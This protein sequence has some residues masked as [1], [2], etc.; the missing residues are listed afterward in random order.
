MYAKQVILL[1]QGTISV[2]YVGP[3]HYYIL[4]ISY[5]QQIKNSGVRSLFYF[6]LPLE[7]IAS[8]KTY[9]G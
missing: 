1:W 4:H 2:C 7:G 5:Q 9:G 8:N 3:T 6:V